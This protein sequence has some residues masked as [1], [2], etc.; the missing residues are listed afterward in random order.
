MLIPDALTDDDIRGLEVEALRTDD[1]ACVVR[2]LN[3]RVSRL[4]V[5]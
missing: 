4:P 3:E 5:E 2:E 1:P